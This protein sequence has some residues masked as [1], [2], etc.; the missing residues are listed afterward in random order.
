MCSQGMQDET[1]A[2]DEATA[3]YGGLLPTHDNA[4]AELRF[5]RRHSTHNIQNMTLALML[6]LK[7]NQEQAAELKAL[8]ERVT[9]LETVGELAEQVSDEPAVKSANGMPLPAEILKWVNYYLGAPGVVFNKAFGRGLLSRHDYLPYHHI[10]QD[11]MKM[12]VENFKAA[13]FPTLRPMTDVIE[14]KPPIGGFYHCADGR[15]TA[16]VIPV[17]GWFWCIYLHNVGESDVYVGTEDRNVKSWMNIVEPITGQALDYHQYR[18][19]TENPR[20]GYPQVDEPG[21]RVAL[22]DL[23]DNMV[24]DTTQWAYW[25]KPGSTD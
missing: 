18:R 23:Y 19:L 5:V 11:P 6:A 12:T 21:L 10:G 9:N 8:R 16:L 2:V 7:T 22:K 4:I 20:L 13:L 24:N 25:Q 1:P 17:K 3:M 15:G 14:M